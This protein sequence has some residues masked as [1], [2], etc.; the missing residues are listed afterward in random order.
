MD[1]LLVRSASL[2][3]L[4]SRPLKAYHS[5]WRAYPSPL[6]Q[7]VDASNTIPVVVCVQGT[8]F[9]RRASSHFDAW[10]LSE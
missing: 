3:C 4:T 7:G 2:A 6:G 10:L 9:V 5:T 8:S 1:A